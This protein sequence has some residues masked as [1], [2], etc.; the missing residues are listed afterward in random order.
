METIQKEYRTVNNNTYKILISYNRDK[1]YTKRRGFYLFINKVELN[2]LGTH[3]IE[4]YSLY[5]GYRAFILETNRLS[6][7]SKKKALNIV[8]EEIILNGVNKCK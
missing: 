3:T 5:D 2:N 7:K 6:E 4:T 1:T 8:T